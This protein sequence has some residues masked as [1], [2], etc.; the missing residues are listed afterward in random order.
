MRCAWRAPA[1]IISPAGRLGVAIAD[2]LVARG[3]VLLG[4]D[5]GELT[6]DG[7]AFLA[8]G[9]GIDLARVPR[10]RAFCR[11]CLDWSE[12]RPHLAGA[13]GAALAD[14]CFS[15]AWI[16]RVRDSRAVNITARGEVAL[17][18]LLRIDSADLRLA[19]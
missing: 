16:E 9:L 18:E 12:R 6:A 8:D 5:G 14:S 4:D 13:V 1:T 2:A 7:A 15:R 3:A 10:R 19:A 11:P 17:R